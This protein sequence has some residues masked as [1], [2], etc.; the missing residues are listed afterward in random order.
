MGAHSDQ[1]DTP[2]TVGS[3]FMV[4]MRN[5]SVMSKTG[6]KRSKLIS[7]NILYNNHSLSC[8]YTQKLAIR[9]APESIGVHWL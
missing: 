4:E 1:S 5:C 2:L 8:E 9:T 7:I 6:A 3:Y